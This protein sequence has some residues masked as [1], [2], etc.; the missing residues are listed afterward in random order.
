MSCPSSS[1][2]FIKGVLLGQ[3]GLHDF[4]P[5]SALQSLQT[6]STSNLFSKKIQRRVRWCAVTGNDGP[7]RW[8]VEEYH[9]LI[10]IGFLDDRRVELINGHL[11]KML[12]QSP[13]HADSVKFLYDTLSEAL[14]NRAIVR[15]SKPITLSDSEPEPD[16][17]IVSGSRED[18][19]KRHPTPCDIML[20]AEISKSTISKNCGD[21]LG[22]YA[23]EGIQE[24]WIINLAHHNVRV[25]KNP[26]GSGYSYD[27]IFSSGCIAPAAFPDCQ[28]DVEEIF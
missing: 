1:V 13:E 21:K 6:C 9:Q 15:D 20:V 25:L 24:F 4:V 27:R 7:M 12:P 18:Y 5:L 3:S 11:I 17:A 14:K 10:D 8:T 19:K 16:I 28:V 2:C 23:T 22:L 26:K